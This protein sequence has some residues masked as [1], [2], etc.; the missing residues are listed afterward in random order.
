MRL[1]MVWLMAVGFGAFAQETY[2]PPHNRP[3]PAVERLLFRAFAQERAPLDLRAGSMDL[4]LF[5]LRTD[6]ALEMRRTPGFRLY[7]APATTL[8]LLLNPAPAPPGRL[9]PFALKEVRQAMQYL[10]DREFIARNLFRGQAL[11]M[12][13]PASPLDY[14]FLTVYDLVRGA[15]FR[16]DAER[17]RGLIAQAMRQA[18]AELVGGGGATGGARPPPPHRPGGGRAAGHRGPGAGPAGGGRV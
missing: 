3:G 8:S 15:G 7:E 6:A 18:G 12:V 1:L 13:S 4:Y 2:R 17:A 16:H 10:V 11:P 14:D 9:N 5:G